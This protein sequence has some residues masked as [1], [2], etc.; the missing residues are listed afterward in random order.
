MELA[1]IEQHLPVFLP[2]LQVT[3]R[4]KEREKKREREHIFQ[5]KE[6]AYNIFYQIEALKHACIR[7]NYV[8]SF[9]GPCAVLSQVYVRFL[10]LIKHTSVRF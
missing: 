6:A 4:K 7:N 10:A 2:F 5:A 9:D 1:D 8:Y 3:L